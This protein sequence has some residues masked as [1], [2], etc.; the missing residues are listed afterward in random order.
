M[1][2]HLLFCLHVLAFISFR[3]LTCHYSP[4]FLQACCDVCGAACTVHTDLH[5]HGAGERRKVFVPPLRPTSL[6]LLSCDLNHCGPHFTLVSP[7]YLPSQRVEFASAGT[8][9]TNRMMRELPKV[10]LNCPDSCHARN[11][12]DSHHH[13]KH[14]ADKRS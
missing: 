12:L 7:S 13:I 10:R 11:P 3:V 4:F 9:T 2:R 8:A 1:V 6:C 5:H 14:L